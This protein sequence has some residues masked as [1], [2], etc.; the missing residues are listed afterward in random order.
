[1]EYTKGIWKRNKFIIECNGREIAH[2]PAPLL[3]FRK[4]ELDGNAQLICAAVNSCQKVNAENPLA[5]AEAIPELVQK[6]H[7]A[8]NQIEYL[9]DKFKE[10]G[11]GNGTIAQIDYLL[12]KIEG[13]GV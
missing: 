6:L 10:T 12:S 3:A 9:H 4:P 11:S 1:M 7:D 2:L 8:R 5:V 13:K